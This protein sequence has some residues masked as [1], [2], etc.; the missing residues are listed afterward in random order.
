MNALE[1]RNAKTM[2]C[3]GIESDRCDS[4]AFSRWSA[5]KLLTAV[6]FSDAARQA[7]QP[8]RARQYVHILTVK[9]ASTDPTGP[10]RP[11]Q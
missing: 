11:R 7:R 6:Q 5:P 4:N 9:N 2:G 3:A 10:D 8:D 1:P